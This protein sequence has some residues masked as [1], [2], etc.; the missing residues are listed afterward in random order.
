MDKGKIE[1]GVET[2][3]ANAQGGKDCLNAIE[4]TLNEDET[5]PTNAGSQ[6][7]RYT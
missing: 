1:E 4:G 6:N 5:R 3:R 7:V 2:L